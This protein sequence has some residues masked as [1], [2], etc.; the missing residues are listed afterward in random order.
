[1]KA[2]TLMF[3]FFSVGVTAV[4]QIFLKKGMSATEVQQGLASG[5]TSAALSIFA[6]PSVLGGLALYALGALAWLL[7]LSRAPVSFAYPFVGLGFV[8]T[9]VLAWAILGEAISAERAAGTA[10]VALGVVLIARGG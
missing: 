6:N 9:S 4:A 8:L 3:I 2:A 1:V 7:A 10:L 5:W